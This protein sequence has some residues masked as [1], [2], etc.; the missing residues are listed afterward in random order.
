MKKLM[1]RTID[2]DNNDPTEAEILCGLNEFQC[3]VYHINRKK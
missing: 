3:S 1:S 2:S